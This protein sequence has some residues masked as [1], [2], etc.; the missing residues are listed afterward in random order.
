MADNHRLMATTKNIKRELNQVRAKKDSNLLGGDFGV[1]ILGVVIDQ[2]YWGSLLQTVVI[3]W[4]S[5]FICGFSIKSKYAKNIVEKFGLEKASIKRTSA[6][7]H[8]KILKDSSRTQVDESLYRRIIGILL[9]LTASRPDIVFVVAICARY[10][11]SPK[12]SHLLNATRII[13]YIS[14]T[15]DY[16]LLFIFDTSSSLVG[17]CDTGCA[18]SFEDR[19]STSKDCFFLGNNLI[20]WF[21]K[22]R[23]CVSLSTAKAEYIAAGSS[24]TQLI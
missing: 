10:Q 2:V 21:S 8:A 16:D 4:L 11:F 13:K 20:S 1:E 6:L 24:F 3:V 5:D 23:N 18:K 9:Y 17:Y 14:G 7:T 22:K 15:N 12:T 19:K